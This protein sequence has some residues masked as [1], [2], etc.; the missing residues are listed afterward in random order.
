M[1]NAYSFHSLLLSGVKSARSLGGGKK[2]PKLNF[3]QLAS[4]S[5]PPGSPISKNI[6]LTSGTLREV[7]PLDVTFLTKYTKEILKNT[8][9]KSS[10]RITG[11][12]ASFYTYIDI[13]TYGVC[14]RTIHV[15]NVIYVLYDISD[16]YDIWHLAFGMNIYIN[17]VV[18]SALKDLQ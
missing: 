6:R 14:Q 15:I 12:S 18:Y 17:I 4:L 10:N 5:H 8:K 13:H 1:E 2:T 11:P 9:E 7:L 3:N 16:I